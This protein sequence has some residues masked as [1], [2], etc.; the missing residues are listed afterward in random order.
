M[1]RTPFD[2]VIKSSDS[3]LT[4]FREVYVYERGTTDEVQIFTDEFAGTVLPQPIQSDS[5]ARFPDLWVETPTRAS[6]FLT[7][8]LVNPVQQWDAIGVGDIEFIHEAPLRTD[9]P[10]IA[11][12]DNPIIE[13]VTRINQAPPGSK[14]YEGQVFGRHVVPAGFEVPELLQPDVTLFADGYGSGHIQIAADNVTQGYGIRLRNARQTVRGLRLEQE[15]LVNPALGQA[16]SLESAT[17]ASISDIETDGF[18]GVIAVGETEDGRTSRWTCEKVVG[19]WNANQGL[20]VLD[21]IGSINGKARQ[22]N[23]NGGAQLSLTTNLVVPGSM[24]RLAP[25]AGITMDAGF[26]NDLT[27]Q[28]TNSNTKNIRALA[29][30]AAGGTYTLTFDG[31]TTAPIP[32]NAVAADVQSALE[33]LSSIDPGDIAVSGGPGGAEMILIIFADGS[34]P[35][36]TTNSASLTGGRATATVEAQV[37]SGYWLGLEIVTSDLDTFDPGGGLTTIVNQHFTNCTFDHYSLAGTLVVNRGRYMHH[38]WFNGTRASADTGGDSANGIGLVA[39][40]A[41]DEDFSDMEFNGGA[42]NVCGNS[43]ALLTSGDQVYQLHVRG[44]MGSYKLTFAGVET[45]AIYPDLVAFDLE[46]I[47][48]AHP[49]IGARDVRVFGGPGDVEGREVPYF[50]VLTGAL[51]NAPQT[52]TVTSD[53]LSGGTHAG[54]V[55]EVLT[56]GRADAGP[57]FDI[58]VGATLY[59]TRFHGALH[60]TSMVQLG[61][62]GVAVTGEMAR[63]GDFASCSAYYAETLKDLQDFVIKP[64]NVSVRPDTG[65]VKHWPY[66]AR[67]AK[68]KVESP[69]GHG[70]SG[71]RLLHSAYGRATSAS[72]VTGTVYF[73]HPSASDQADNLISG[74]T[75]G[76]IGGLFDFD[77]ADYESDGLTTFLTLAG[78]LSCAGTPT[79]TVTMG[80]YPVTMN[81]GN[82]DMG[83]VVAGTTVGIAGAAQSFPRGKVTFDAALLAAGTYVPGYILSANAGANFDL[84]A[85]VFVENGL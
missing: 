8:D 27:M 9:L 34:A 26:Y 79:T 46:A 70:D 45:A 85:R 33:A 5:E 73:L 23:M 81:A 20:R 60:R 25:L 13:L 15:N 65:F 16:F 69:W 37:G 6:V 59:D 38:N 40:H 76:A 50:V 62:E 54:A 56:T 2:A 17:N 30:R 78:F 74:T 18:G 4:P 21:L 39:L 61:M 43:G 80:L 35:I 55:L 1:A 44:M 57:T 3:K 24:M 10:E 42:Y 19:S 22:F 32:W 47:L 14:R 84:K 68:R 72:G 82:M 11:A 64:R 28:A 29:V 48:I 12:A 67:S 77:P 7:T 53:T 52:L 83:A 41:A 51:G 75:V 71:R 31:Q 63:G 36:L 49:S 58:E 66:A